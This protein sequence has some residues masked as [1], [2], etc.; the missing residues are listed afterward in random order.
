MYIFIPNFTRPSCLA[1]LSD[2]PPSFLDSGGHNL[3]FSADI[4][5]W[6]CDSALLP[7]HPTAPPWAS[8]RSTRQN[9]STASASTSA[10]TGAS[11]TATSSGAAARRSV[12]V[13]T[14]KTRAQPL[15]TP[16]ESW[17]IHDIYGYLWC[18]L[19][20]QQ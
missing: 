18:F 8:G 2:K 17:L 4:P 7:G 6:Q 5:R 3:I 20:A 12:A 13:G 15:T 14:W 19:E 9:N 10:S 1:Q 11:G 16:G